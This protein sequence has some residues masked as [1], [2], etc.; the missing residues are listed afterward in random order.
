MKINQE[1]SMTEY[2]KM[3]ALYPGGLLDL[4]CC[5]DSRA[6]CGILLMKNRVCSL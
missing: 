6:R 4:R 1:D 5:I 3:L 2:E